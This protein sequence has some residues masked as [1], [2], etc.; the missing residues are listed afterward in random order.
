MI[1]PD[2]INIINILSILDIN[3]YE[4]EEELLRHQNTIKNS[5]R[6]LNRSTIILY[7]YFTIKIFKNI[8]IE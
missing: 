7:I 3:N 1:V 4:N 2:N 5:L 8:F 6:N